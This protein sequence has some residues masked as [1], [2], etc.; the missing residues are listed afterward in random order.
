MFTNI[1]PEVLVWARREGGY[2][3]PGDIARKLNISVDL[4][5]K[6]ESDGENVDFGILELIAKTYKRQTSVFF[7][8]KVPEGVKKPKDH[9]NLKVDSSNFSPETFLA[10][11]RTV[12][13]LK[14]ARELNGN[15]HW[16]KRY[17]WLKQFTGKTSLIDREAKLLRNLL[18]AP[19]EVQ[20]RQKDPETAFRF[21]RDKI[22]EE[23]NIFVFQFSIPN[24][25]MDGFSYTLDGFPYAIVIDNSNSKQ[26][27]RK[28]FTL[29]HELSHIFKHESEI[30]VTDFSRG[31]DMQNELACND[32]AGKFLIPV[33]A[34]RKY[35][36]PEEIYK[37]ALRLNISSEAYL[38][39]MHQ[40][41]SLNEDI[42]YSL[43]NKMKR[44]A[45]EVLKMKKEISKGKKI[46]LSGIVRSKSSRGKKFYG[47]VTDAAQSGRITYST[48]SDLLS[49]KIG[50]IGA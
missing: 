25:E 30:C 39:R 38:R 32:F 40:V 4:L 33:E 2:R 27:V 29:F 44:K 48:A 19:L 10:F 21:W 1:N 46:L 16:T 47:L 43:L 5:K 3:S 41:Y 26:A 28:I 35:D 6:W 17:S 50:S 20:M 7:L 8:P 18:N 31:S 12:R 9:R 23:L 22:E 13:Y 14:K 11:R 37:A 15:E 34:V 49:L 36:L 42:Y 24:D 45:I